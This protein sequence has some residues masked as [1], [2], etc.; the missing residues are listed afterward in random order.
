MKQFLLGYLLWA[1]IIPTFS[2]AQTAQLTQQLGKTVLYGDIAL[3]PDRSHVAWVQSTAATPLNQTKIQATSGNS[4]AAA[5][6][7]DAAGERI[8]TEPVWS[9]DSKTLSVFSTAGE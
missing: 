2:M 3:S 1:T 9:P 6:K 8:D 4:S 5:V 7:L